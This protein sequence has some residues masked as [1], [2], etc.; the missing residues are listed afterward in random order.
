[1]PAKPA[2]TK[3]RPF[4]GQRAARGREAP[5]RDRTRGPAAALL[6]RCAPVCCVPDVAGLHRPRP[7]GRCGKTSRL[8]RYVAKAYGEAS[9]SGRVSV[10][11]TRHG[12]GRRSALC[13]RPVS[14]KPL[15]NNHLQTISAV[16]ADFCAFGMPFA[17][18]PTE[19]RSR[20]GGGWADS[21]RQEAC[22]VRAG[23]LGDKGDEAARSLQ[24]R[25]NEISFHPA[26]GGSAGDRAAAMP[27]LR[28]H[29]RGPHSRAGRSRRR[30]ESLTA[31]L[32]ELVRHDAAFFDAASFC[33]GLD[34]SPTPRRDP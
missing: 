13:K 24:A 1:M 29:H 27:A 4:A 5:E 34:R 3:H 25:A 26:A 17:P 19:S 16:R 31:A 22:V 28:Q 21:E 6:L 33:F 30:R 23:S 18:V 32:S 7:G 9:V 15:V 8:T 10:A 14:H 11:L 20:K 2:P 12:D